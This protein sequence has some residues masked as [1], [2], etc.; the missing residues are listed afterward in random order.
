MKAESRHCV[1]IDFLLS[2]ALGTLLL[3]RNMILARSRQ[4]TKPDKD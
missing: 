1:A 3:A 4:K 2:I